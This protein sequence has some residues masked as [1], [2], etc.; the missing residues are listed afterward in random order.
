M[1][2]DGTTGHIEYKL[3]FCGYEIDGDLLLTSLVLVQLPAS[4]TEKIRSGKK[5]NSHLVVSFMVLYKYMY[6]AKIIVHSLE[7]C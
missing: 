6:D 5:Y 1:G 2:F 7:I 3:R 4:L